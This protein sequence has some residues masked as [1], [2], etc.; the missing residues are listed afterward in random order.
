MS[1]NLLTPLPSLRRETRRYDVVVAGG[2]MAGVGAAI[3]AARH[4]ARVA[5]IQDRPVL[6]GN[7]SKEIRVWL[8]GASGG[9]N[10]IYFRETG[11]MEELLLENQ[12]RNPEGN[13]DLW[14]SVLIDKAYTQQNLEL[15]LNSAVL[16]V[17]PHPQP[18]SLK[19][20]GE[21]ER[22]IK[23]VTALT[24]HSEKLTTFEADYFID[25]TGDGTLGYL[26]GAP[27]MT[28]RES[29]SEYNESLA[30]AERQSN[31]L[32]GSILFLAKDAGHP[33]A[34]HPPSF[35]HKFTEKDFRPGRNPVREFDWV[36]GGFWF[37]EWGGTFDTIHD[38]EQ[39]KFELLKIAYGVFDYLKNDP[40][41]KEKNKNYTLE[42]IGTIPGKRESRRFVGDYVMTEQDIVERRDFPDAIAFGGWNLDD[43]APKGFFDDNAPAS[44]HTHI[45]G[46]YNIPLRSLYSKSVANL[47]FAGRNVSVT[48]IALTSVR[49]MLTCAQMGE[50]AGATAAFCVQKKISPR[51]VANTEVIAELRERLL[52]DD[53]H[54]VGARSDSPDDLTR[55][56]GAVVKASSQLERTAL[57]HSDK[58]VALDVDRMVLFPACAGQL[59]HV[60]ALLSVAQDTTIGWQLHRG[61]G[62]GGSIP[63][64]TVAEGAVAVKAGGTQWVRFP[65]AATVTTDA[66]HMLELKKNPNVSWHESGE[67]LVGLKSFA[68]CEQHSSR[69]SNK[70]SRF[71]CTRT[72]QLCVR[73]ANDPRV[74][75]PANAVNGYSRPFNMPNLWISK[76]SDFK[77]PEWLEIAWQGAQSVRE[78][79]FLFDSDLDRHVTNT[80]VRMPYSIEP[81]LVKDY[82]VELRQNGEWKRVAEVRENHLRR[83]VHI[84]SEAMS[85]DAVRLVVRTTNGTPRA[86]VYSV[87]VRNS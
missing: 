73:L 40:A 5:L 64:A 20:R 23:S 59:S 29:K 19:G 74:Y 42:W 47:L 49:V 80:W 77:Q 24:L 69:H 32:G 65:V 50:A 26:A 67:R 72:R 7:G 46:L 86:Q 75:A 11:L 52:R 62:R 10:A 21:S 48:H 66:W 53:H 33:V 22:R 30:P 4:G 9:H 54:V 43:H 1:E 81:D 39:I 45:P 70:H 71:A 82:D 63:A 3:T 17:T 37:V 84:L 78:I 57:E 12:F 44:M 36:K 61:D 51:D 2:G 41:L 28:G 31:T 15:F 25:C 79:Q 58:L 87:S 85:A 6:G 35:A 76:H 68:S 13:A 38:N 14:D 16:E 56:P 34:F 18:L 83:R 8:Q 60:E 27:Y 55:R